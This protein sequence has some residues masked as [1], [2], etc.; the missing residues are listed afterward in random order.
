M[1]VSI[2]FF[3]VQ[4]SKA[5]CD[6]NFCKFMF[7]WACEPIEYPFPCPCAALEALLYR[8]RENPA[9]IFESLHTE[10]LKLHICLYHLHFI[11]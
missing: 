5:A 6:R 7:P 3:T 11:T 1:C 9:L 4:L 2:Y 8:G 10:D